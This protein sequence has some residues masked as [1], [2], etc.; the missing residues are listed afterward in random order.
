VPR[1]G[2]SRL[3]IRGWS[4]GWH[5]AAIAVLRRPDIFHAAI[6]GALVRRSFA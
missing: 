6:A 4:F 1:P 2:L 5:L 3:P